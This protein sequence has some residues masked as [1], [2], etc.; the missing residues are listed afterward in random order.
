MFKHEKSQKFTVFLR[1]VELVVLVV[2]VVLVALVLMLCWC[3]C[4]CCI[5]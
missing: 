2:L 3:W 4:W 1:G 5:Y